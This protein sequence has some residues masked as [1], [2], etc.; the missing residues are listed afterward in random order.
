MKEGSFIAIISAYITNL[1]KY[2]EGDLVGKWHDFP[3]TPEEIAETFEEIGINGVEYEEYFITDCNAEIDGI[4][5]RLGEYTGIDEINY[6]AT[7]LDEMAPHELE[8][9]QAAI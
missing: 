7:L 3:T 6:L 9:Y 4:C 1:G 5:D 2:N 8:L